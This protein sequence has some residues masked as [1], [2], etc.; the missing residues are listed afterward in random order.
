MPRFLIRLVAIAALASCAVA[1][2]DDGQS[3][4]RCIGEHGEIVFSGVA[5]GP[6]SRADSRT[7][8]AQRADPHDAL[9]LICPK[10]PDALRTVFA[11]ALTR[12]D[13]NA[14]A[15][16]VRWQGVGG[17]QARGRL[18]EIAELSARPLIGIELGGAST[19]TAATDSPD[20]A[21]ENDSAPESLIVRTGSTDRLGPREQEFRV[22]AGGGC[23]W[24]DW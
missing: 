16:L 19:S 18:Q 1:Q 2:A 24:L 6:A 20:S 15:S 4:H 17:A 14:I 9:A 10:S 8:V 3:V 11:D 7:D 21:F 22:S 13:T 12:R 23:Y 5:C